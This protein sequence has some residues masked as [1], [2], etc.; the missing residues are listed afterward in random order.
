MKTLFFI[1][2]TSLLIANELSWVNEQIKAIKPSREG[3]SK[4]NI[5]EVIS[6]FTFLKKEKKQISKNFNSQKA[7][8]NRTSKK[9]AKK[10][11]TT[12]KTFKLQAIINTSALING[13]W[14]KRYSKV[15]KY[16]LTEVNRK[17]VILQY[18]KTKIT[19]SIHTSNKKINITRKEK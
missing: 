7:T 15:G 12:K 3:I 18:K 11:N 9:R 17:N 14:Y 2:L 1:L 10:Y 13:K 16:K 6:P 5:S 19:L 8:R 4:E